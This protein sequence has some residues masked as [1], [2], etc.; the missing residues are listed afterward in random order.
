MLCRVI[1]KK[2]AELAVMA[3]LLTAYF[4]MRPEISLKSTNCY[5]RVARAGQKGNSFRRAWQ[6]LTRYDTM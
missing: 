3:S 1:I 6:S 4:I 5:E 2:Q